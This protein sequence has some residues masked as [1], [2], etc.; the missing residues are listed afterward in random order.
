MRQQHETD[1]DAAD[2]VSHDDLEEGQVRIVGQPGN[3][4]DGQSTGLGRDNRQRDCPPGNVAPSKK[5]V[6]QGT[7][8][9]AEAEAEQSD[10][11]QVQSDDREIDVV[12]AHVFTSGRK[13]LT[14][15][16]AEE[17][18]Q[19]SLR[20]PRC[21]CSSLRSL[22]L[23]FANSAVKGSSLAARTEHTTI[24]SLPAESS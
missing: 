20:E 22:R 5:V 18:P 4:D 7:L 13:L 16:I 9:L 12:Q 10:A 1:H 14:A 2:N 3:A 24:F 8:L 6:A 23:F 15:E 21:R 11:R 17:N 19:R